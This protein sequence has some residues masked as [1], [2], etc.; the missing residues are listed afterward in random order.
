MSELSNQSFFDFA[1][2]DSSSSSITPTQP[3]AAPVG[4]MRSI[5]KG[6]SPFPSQSGLSTSAP[7]PP[8]IN[9]EPA[10]SQSYDSSLQAGNIPMSFGNSEWGAFPPNPED[11]RAMTPNGSGIARMSSSISNAHQ[12]F[13]NHHTASIGLG[14]DTPG[15]I[16]GDTSLNHCEMPT[17]HNPTHH[18]STIPENGVDPSTPESF[19]SPGSAD[20]NSISSKYYHDPDVFEPAFSAYAHNHDAFNISAGDD[21]QEKPNGLESGAGY[22]FDVALDSLGSSREL[23]GISLGIHDSPFAR[24]QVDTAPSNV[25]EHS[26]P[27]HQLIEG[28][29]KLQLGESNDGEEYTSATF[30]DQHDTSPNHAGVVVAQGLD[31]G[32]EQK[33]LIPHFDQSDVSDA[34]AAT[35]MARY[36]G[37]EHKDFTPT[38]QQVEDGLADRP[39]LYRD[40]ILEALESTGEELDTP[41]KYSSLEEAREHLK[42]QSRT[43]GY[44]PTIPQTVMQKRAIVKALYDLMWSTDKAQ[45]NEGMKKPFKDNRPNPR[46]VELAC[47]EVLEAAVIREKEGA[48]TNKQQ[49][50]TVGSFAS[51]M[52]AIMEGI[53]C[54]KTICHHLLRHDYLHQFVDD[55]VGQRQRVISNQRLN[56]DKADLM[57]LGKEMRVKAKRQTKKTTTPDQNRSRAKNAKASNQGEIQ[58]QQEETQP[59]QGKM[60]PQQVVNATRPGRNLAPAPHSSPSRAMHTTAHYAD[61]PSNAYAYPPPYAPQAM[62]NYGVGQYPGADTPPQV[63]QAVGNL[64]YVTGNQPVNRNYDVSQPAAYYHAQAIQR[65]QSFGYGHDVAQPA[66]YPYTQDARFT[67]VP[68]P[69]LN[70]SGNMYTQPPTAANSPQALQPGTSTAHPKKKR[71]RQNNDVDDASSHSKR[72]C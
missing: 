32:T 11:I 22:G 59:Q 42:V 65:A 43:Q 24:S 48:F 67:R 64:T 41:I 12:P 2:M 66:P 9:L 71:I 72:R 55:P 29:L 7:A 56:K 5:F 30:S 26:G 21:T 28:S 27:A 51:R 3:K 39:A 38:P 68:E 33:G 35:A 53:S 23:L 18:A 57:K 6:S 19:V 16:V 1:G 10:F 61:H 50:G 13:I 49:K 58:P 15:N 62:Q 36:D 37:N 8:T 4:R 54:H 17:Q 34:G 14:V 25:V 60:Q 69:Y 31:G 47:W 40:M 63:H 52:A 70:M 20:N 45:D 44:D 46:R